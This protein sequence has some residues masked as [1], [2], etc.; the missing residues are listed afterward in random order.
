MRVIIFFSLLVLCNTALFSQ[1]TPV[2]KNI[3]FE[4]AGIRGVAYSG[5]IAEME[6]AGKMKDVEK[7]A[8]TSAGAIVAMI[9]SLG[10]TAAEIKTIVTGINFRKLNDGRFFFPGGI[11]RTSKYFG[12]YRGVRAADWLGKLIKQKTG[13]EDITFETLHQQGYKDLYITGTNLTRQQLVVFSR[14]TY[15]QMKVKDAVRIS[16]GIPLYFEAIFADST[17][18]VAHHPNKKEGLD[19]LVD[20]GLTGNFPIQIFDSASSANPYTA[21]FRIDRDE[22]IL[23]DRKSRTLAPMEINNFK[24]YIAALYNMVIENLN[25]QQLSADDWKR[26]VSISDGNT[27]PRIRELSA[28]EINR[29]VENGRRATREFLLN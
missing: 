28:G 21:G 10:Y 27:G 20:G 26:T 7:V 15:P 1:Q 4:G 19:V 24:Q 29:L 22:Q 14:E 3:V 12:W 8:G 23:H 13:N 16:M 2:I 11:H 5:V 25:R 17:G 9:V 6:H 18:A